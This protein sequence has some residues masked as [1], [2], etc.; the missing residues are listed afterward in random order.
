MVGDQTMIH[1]SAKAFEDVV[2]IYIQI[3]CGMRDMGCIGYTM[4]VQEWDRGDELMATELNRGD[5]T[6]RLYILQP[7]NEDQSYAVRADVST[8]IGSTEHMV[9]AWLVVS[10]GR[11]WT[12]HIEQTLRGKLREGFEHDV[13]PRLRELAASL[14]GEIKDF[15]LLARFMVEES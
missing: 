14:N 5:Y 10:Q 4:V 15:T 11:E 9:S 1:Q 7:N 6:L 3:A 12:S 8:T 13:D 2:A